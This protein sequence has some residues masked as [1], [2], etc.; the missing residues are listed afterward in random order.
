MNAIICVLLHNVF[1][2]ICEYLNTTD[3]LPACDLRSESEGYAQAEDGSLVCG[4]R[5]ESE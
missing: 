5:I 2:K 4:S 1:C 3:S